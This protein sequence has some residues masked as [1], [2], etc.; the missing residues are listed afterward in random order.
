[1]TNT[2]GL[3]DWRRLIVQ[4]VGVKQEVAQVDREHLWQFR[5]PAVAANERDIGGAEAAL[6]ESIDPQ[7]R[8]FLKYANGW[9]SFYQT[10]DLFGTADLTGS[11]YGHALEMLDNL[12][13]AILDR[14]KI[15]RQ[16][17]IPIAATAVDL[18]LFV[19][20]R[21][22]SPK[23]GQVIWF[24]GQEIDRYEN[25]GEFYL[26]MLECNRRELFDLRKRW[27]PSSPKA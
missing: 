2:D 23:P 6:G 9:P 22:S 27:A 15:G 14:S 19:M 4:M 16:D 1:V 3:I 8:S 25:F 11:R 20:T 24:A 7:Y 18:D 13:D 5:L 12:E 26:A 10:V 17:V 21:M